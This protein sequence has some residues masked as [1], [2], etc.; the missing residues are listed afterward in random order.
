MVGEVHGTITVMG[1]IYWV[2][3]VAMHW[4]FGNRMQA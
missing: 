4:G 3:S 2:F 1:A